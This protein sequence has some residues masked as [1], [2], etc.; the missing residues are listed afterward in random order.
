MTLE[1]LAAQ[2][3]RHT[4]AMRRISELPSEK[5]EELRSKNEELL[6]RAKIITPSGKLASWVLG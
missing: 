4:E 3:R 1:K 5:Q 6:K 2:A